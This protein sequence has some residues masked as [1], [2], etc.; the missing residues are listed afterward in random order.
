MSVVNAMLRGGHYKS[1]QHPLELSYICH[2]VQFLGEAG[3]DGGGPRREFFTL[4]A[5][6]TRSS[7]FEG[8][9]S[10]CFLRHDSIALQVC[11]FQH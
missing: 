9:A 11:N 2:Q 5:K 10:R 4:L 7:L 8:E 1:P 3:E 6:D